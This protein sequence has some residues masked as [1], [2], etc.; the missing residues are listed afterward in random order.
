M[1]VLYV[2]ATPI[3]NLGDVSARARQVIADVAVLFVEDTRVTAKLLNAVGVSKR[4]ISCHANAPPARY[5]QILAALDAGDAALITDAGTPAISDPGAKLTR[6]AR[7]RGHVVSPIPGPSAVCA[8][9]SASGMPADKFTFL[10]FLPTS[11]GKRAKALEAALELRHTVVLYEAPHRVQKTLALLERLAPERPLCVCR[12]L[13]KL[14]EE[15]YVGA[16]A[17][18]LKHFANPRGEFVF[19]IGG[20][21]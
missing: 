3:G 8:A 11:A 21:R 20:G 15:I 14:H 1:S 9:L 18:A 13:T 12:E 4:M 10:G 17:D 16:A 2:V 5:E 7:E 19:V 6:L